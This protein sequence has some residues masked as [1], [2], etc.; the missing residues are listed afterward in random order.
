M[1]RS[2]ADQRSAQGCELWVVRQGRGDGDDGLAENMAGEH[3][4]KEPDEDPEGQGAVGDSHV[5]RVHSSRDSDKGTRPEDLKK[6]DP[7]R[8]PP[9]DSATCR[10]SPR[11]S[12][13]GRIPE[14]DTS[15]PSERLR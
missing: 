5:Q 10:R 15:N 6:L 12:W 11:A 3:P 9:L 2:G 1:R 13:P 4:A 8:R 14:D 7:P